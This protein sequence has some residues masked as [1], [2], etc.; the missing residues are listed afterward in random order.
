MVSVMLGLSRAA[1]AAFFLSAFFSAK[2]SGRQPRRAAWAESG[3]TMTMAIV[4]TKAER[5]S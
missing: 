1:P 2:E 4:R 3:K 5:L